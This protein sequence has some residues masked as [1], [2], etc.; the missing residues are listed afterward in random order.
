[1]KNLMDYSAFGLTAKPNRNALSSTN[2]SNVGVTPESIDVF[3]NRILTSG[4]GISV[5]K[6]EHAGQNRSV[7]Y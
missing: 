4:I 3:S 5:L 2:M 6:L 1:M 7:M